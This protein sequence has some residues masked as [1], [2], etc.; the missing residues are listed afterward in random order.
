MS[1][2]PKSFVA[3]LAFL[4]T[5][6]PLCAQSTS[7]FK[8]E[9][10]DR[11]PGWEG[12]HNHVPPAKPLLVKQ[13]FGFSPN[14]HH[15]GKAAGEMGGRIQRSTTPASYAA[16]LAPALTL[17]EKFSASGTFAFTDSQPGS[18]FFFGFFHAAQ[19]G[20][21]GRPI[22][23]LGL[24]F[25]C[26]REGVRLAVRLITG[27]NK[28]C[29]TFITPYV[30]GKFRPTPLK[31]DGTQYHWTLEY[32]PEGADGNGQF[33]FTMRSDTHTSENYGPDLP[34]QSQREADARFPKTTTFIVPVTPGLRKEGATFDRFGAL[35]MM[36]SGDTVTVWFDDLQF[37][38]QTVDFSHDPGWISSGNRISFED[39]D[40]TGAHDFGY[41]ANTQ[42]A[43]GSAPGEVGGRF[44]RSGIYG[45]Y[46]DRVGPLDLTQRLEA[47]GKVKLVT[48]GP[49][50]DMLIGWFQRTNKERSPDESGNFIGVHVGGPTRI[51]HYFMPFVTTSRLSKANIEPAPIFVPGKAY[52]W[53]VIYD[54]DANNGNGE[55]RATLGSESATLKFKPELKKEGGTFDRFG[56]FT[57]QAGG[58]MVNI[59]LDDITYTTRKK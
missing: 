23:S 22:G 32:D 40:L 15:A 36:K 45:Y 8:T 55:L 26:E 27:T 6:A 31:K 38:G 4:V 53:S 5:G 9:H 49:D 57:S 14:T 16:A 41:S 24:D 44:W 43:A 7:T 52:D 39:R 1:C 10:F 28:S 17:D 18:G 54:P 2:F 25:D 56:L 59:F 51:G 3:L 35:N 42:H 30:P 58:Q 29:G 12:H 47:R 50:S 33:T 48:A 19:P 13:D 37:A 34:L 21:S 11:D 20:A 46:A